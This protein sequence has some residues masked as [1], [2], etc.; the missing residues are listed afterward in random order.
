MLW[1]AGSIAFV[2]FGAVVMCI[3]I[4]GGRADDRIELS[5]LIDPS[6]RLPSSAE[7]KVRIVLEGFQNQIPVSDLRKREGISPA[8]DYS[9]AKGFI[10][11][12]DARLNRD[13]LRNAPQ[14]GAKELGERMT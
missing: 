6:I 3:L 4:I 13:S 11:P 7:D 8:L 2:L 1:I 14:S 5:K 12:G 10:D 9:W